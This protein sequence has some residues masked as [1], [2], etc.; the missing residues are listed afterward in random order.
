MFRLIEP[1]F[2]PAIIFPFSQLFGIVYQCYMKYG[3]DTETNFYLT[4]ILQTGFLQVGL[5]I[6]ILQIIL[7]SFNI[8][9]LNKY[10]KLNYQIIPYYL[11]EWVILASPSILLMGCI[12]A[13]ISATKLIMTDEFVYIT[14]TKIVNQSKEEE[15]VV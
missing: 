2:S 11:I 1:H 10:T 6:I 14:A 5:Y 9:L 15:V 7:F 3:K 4:S 8:Y 13:W 12:P